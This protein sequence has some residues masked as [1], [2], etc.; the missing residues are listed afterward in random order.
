MALSVREL[1]E[2]HTRGMSYEELERQGL[3]FDEEV[4]SIND[5]VDLQ[6]LREKNA[7]LLKKAQQEHE[8]NKAPEEPKKPN[9]GQDPTEPEKAPEKAD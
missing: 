6:E 5:L 1:L 4:P 7:E 8:Q 3:Y 2:N 9:T